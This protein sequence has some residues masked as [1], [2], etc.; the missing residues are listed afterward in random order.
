MN[1]ITFV[2]ISVLALSL[3]IPSTAVLQ[4]YLGILGVT[5][6]LAIASF[7][8]FLFIKYRRALSRQ[9]FRITELQVL[10]LFAITFSMLLVI[11]LVAYPVANSGIVGGG[12]DNDDALNIAVAELLNGR[13][14][15]YPK[16]YLGNPISPLPGALL[17]AVPFVALFGNSAYQ[18]LF[19]ISAFFIAMKSYFRDGRLAL[20][21]LWV[22][23]A[24]PIVLNLFIIGSDYISNSLYVLLFILWMLSSASRPDYG[25]CKKILPAISLGIGLSS[26]SNFVL[27]L[28]LI[29]SALIQKVGWRHAIKYTAVTCITFTVI[30]TPFY[31][32]DPQGFSPLHT[33]NILGQFQSV[34]PFSGFVIPAIT[35]IIALILAL[36]QSIDNTLD[37]LFR[38]CMIVLA[39]PVLCGIALSSINSGRVDFSF[40]FFGAF[41]LFFGVVSAWRTLFEV[42]QLH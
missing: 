2:S 37:N 32:Y 34:V 23:F 17:L 41:F 42:P 36:S 1:R 29:F 38:N 30:T 14:P 6:Y 3:F 12:S 20:L 39:F 35:G 5:V 18:N 13:Y 28:P 15:Y 26:R 22:I 40:A 11:F 9:I 16:T 27:L 24:S 21:L 4:K 10:W 31:L 19:W 8:F 33:A 7:A 25:E